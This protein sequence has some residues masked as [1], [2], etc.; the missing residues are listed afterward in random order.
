MLEKAK[1]LRKYHGSRSSNN[2]NEKRGIEMRI[3]TSMGIETGLFPSEEEKALQYFLSENR[4][5]ILPPELGVRIATTP[6]EDFDTL[7]A[8]R[9]ILRDSELKHLHHALGFIKREGNWYMADNE[10]GF[11]HPI[12]DKSAVR[13]LYEADLDD[14]HFYVP[15]EPALKD[16]YDTVFIHHPFK[17]PGTQYPFLFK[18]AK[19]MPAIVT[20]RLYL[21]TFEKKATSVSKHTKRHTKKHRKGRGKTHRRRK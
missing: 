7:F 10:V 18:E 17:A 1:T 8:I 9:F 15:D 12:D 13:M 11:L 5:G 4:Y 2:N 3:C 20:H 19:Y 6:P 21:S 16:A 14:I